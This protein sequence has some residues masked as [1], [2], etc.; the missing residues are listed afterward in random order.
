MVDDLA[1]PDLAEK[2]DADRLTALKALRGEIAR[3]IPDAADRELVG[4]AT[5]LR[6]VLTELDS[7]NAGEDADVVDELAG[8]RAARRAGAA[9]QG[10]APGGQ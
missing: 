5:Q 4:L 9:V 8:R 6:L 7:L 10:E 2:L 3:R 1:A